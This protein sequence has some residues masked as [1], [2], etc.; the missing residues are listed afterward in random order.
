MLIDNKTP[1]SKNQIH[2]VFE[3]LEKYIGNGKLDIVTGYFSINALAKLADKAGSVKSFRMILAELSKEEAQ[4]N[5]II[6]LLAENLSI[7]SALNLN[8]SAKKAV[9]F[10]KQENVRI[11]KVHQ[12]F[13]H[14]KAYVYEDDDA[15]HRF[16]IVGSSNLTESGLG[17]KPS[18][19][20]ELNIYKSGGDS[21][22][23]E[24]V[25][26][27]QQLWSGKT[28]SDKIELP[29]KK[30]ISCKDY[31]IG[32]ISN[33]FKEY[34]PHQLYYKV[35]YELF[36][37]DKL[38]ASDEEF[39]K[40]IAHL[41]DTI[42][43]KSLY[44]FQQKGV[45]SLIHIMQKENGAV[46]ADAVGL[47]KTWTALAVMKYFEIKGYKV[48]LFCPKKLEYN[49]RRYLE[50]HGSK[51]E[52]DRLK[53]T[54]R[55]H[56][57]LQNN[58][59]EGYDDGFTLNRYFQNNPKLLIVIDE[60]H[61][62][63]NDKSAR[64]EFLVD[65]ILKQNNDVKV[66]QLSATP[67]N[68]RLIDIRNQFKLIRKGN[69]DGF[70]NSDAE[71]HSL[72][73]LFANAQKE[74]NE[75]QKQ[76]HAKIKDFI[77]SLPQKFFALTDA[78]LVARTRRLI[79]NEFGTLA[80]PEKE[81]P[82]NEYLTPENIGNFKSFD[83]IFEAIQVNMTAYR[84]SEYVGNKKPVS[85]L[86]DPVQREKFLVKMMFI[87]LIKRLESCWFS[88]RNTVEKILNH[89]RNAADK[90]D[91]FIASRKD[92]TI[93]AD[94]IE[95][96]LIDE[97]EETATEYTASEQET[98]AEF[99]LGKKNPIRLSD[100]SNIRLF[101]AHLDNDV[102]K[103]EALK[104][105]LDDYNLKSENGQAADN[106]AERLIQHIHQKRQNRAN[107]KV[108]IFT[109]F[110]DTAEYLFKL[111]RKKGFSKIAYVSGSLSETDDGYKGSKF[112]EILERFAPYTKLYAEKDW[113]YVYE[114]NGLS[115]T[116]PEN[117]EQWKQVI[118]KYDKDTHRKIEKPIDILIATDCLS[119]GQNLQDC[120]CVINYDIHWNP[121]RL[122]QRIGR[123]DR[124]GS[125]NATIMGINFW[126][127]KDYE[128]YLRLKTRVEN[129]MAL[130]TVIGS[131]IE[132]NITP[133]MKKII[134]DN[135]LA[136]RQTE[137]MLS[138]L[139]VTWEDIETGE[140]TIGLNDLSLEEFRQEL[141]EYFREQ[142]KV[143]EEMPNGIYTGF[144]ASPDKQYPQLPQG[145]IA[146]LGY[147]K[148]SD[149][150]PY[151]ELFLLYSGAHGY[152]LYNNNKDILGI[153]RKHKDQPRFVPYDVDMGNEADLNLLS[154]YIKAWIAGQVPQ[155]AAEKIQAL[156]S[157]GISVKK[158]PEDMKIEE[159]FKPENF[160]LITWFV[161]G[162][163][164]YMVCGR[165]E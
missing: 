52:N 105:N 41:K 103:L 99:T 154:S 8:S 62:F 132:E 7:N 128:D 77:Q 38:F 85:I 100:I 149:N 65:N 25:Q 1:F 56:T 151:Q 107:P 122:I 124:L 150:K 120:D 18:G 156:F 126:P 14:A 45:I 164:N 162:A 59:M 2:T 73:S 118:R 137:R 108:L 152:S 31:V 112:E 84:P 141:L 66:L 102:K 67:I 139:Q 61:N 81:P 63:R 68:N 159:K 35:L 42:L 145:V 24:V 138:Q 92:M 83:D 160:D 39:E 40:E 94:I 6:N 5:K 32:L 140:E 54:I 163:N 13:C 64:Y 47:G 87:L 82:V 10:L 36:R 29:E 70:R 60:S 116:P 134:K 96:E 123:I 155:K 88:F 97:L 115:A 129:R 33:F 109:A 4:E 143:F 93:E 57:D 55:F 76:K 104:K 43:Y 157:E 147:P 16:Y 127:G 49:W 106:K 28:T 51:F 21:D 17:L 135:P 98:S 114:K 117:F 3:L 30:I 71:I 142:Q 119:E 110:K 78:L 86:E 101:K 19:N 37:K 27:F 11:R 95:D 9:E 46:L 23:K 48:L 80:F 44:S 79:R 153:L 26:W 121:V 133:E 131:E 53:Y 69:D 161:V 91:R 144:K 12:H 89:H 130:M 148:K 58:R 20:I 111:L 90:V 165:G 136:T 72:Q 75:W 15:R 50:G 113:T 146:L 125:P 74:F 22:Y 158:S 34:S